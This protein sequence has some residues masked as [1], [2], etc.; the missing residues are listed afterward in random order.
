MV[1]KLENIVFRFRALILAAFAAFTLYGGYYATQLS[2][3]AGFEKQ[4]PS[5]H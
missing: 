4:L 5:G 3:D 2:M 1:S